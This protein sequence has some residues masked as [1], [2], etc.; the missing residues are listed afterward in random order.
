MEDIILV[1]KMPAVPEKCDRYRIM[2]YM[3][4]ERM[5]V[6]SRTEG[7]WAQLGPPSFHSGV[8]TLCPSRGSKDPE[9][10]VSS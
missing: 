2:S 7:S 1:F 4:S 8:R 5:G 10:V 9:Q 3:M 6:E